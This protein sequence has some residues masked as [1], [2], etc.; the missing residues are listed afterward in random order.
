M[1]KVR[2]E[3]RLYASLAA[4]HA[5]VRAGEP[6]ALQLKDHTLLA[7]LLRTLRIEPRAVHLAIV[8]GRLVHDSAYVLSD[9]DR[10]GLFPPVGGG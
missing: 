3:V 7:D 9:G 8:N 10:V 2:V 4:S 6:L 5:D 1:R